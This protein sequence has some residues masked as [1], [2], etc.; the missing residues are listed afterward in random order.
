MVGA[1]RSAPVPCHDEGSAARPW[2]LSEE[3]GLSGG[4]DPLLDSSF[5]GLLVVFLMFLCA[6]LAPGLVRDGGS[7]A[8]HAESQ[9][10]CLLA[11]S[12][13]IA[14]SLFLA[15]WTL[16]PGLFVL[17]LVLEPFFRAH[18]RLLC[19]WGSCPVWAWVALLQ[20][21]WA[22][23]PAGSWACF[24]CSSG[25]IGL[26]CTGKVG[27]RHGASPST[28]Q[29]ESEK[30]TPMEAYCFKCRSKREIAAPQRV[31]LKN[32]NPAVTGKCP[33]CSCK[34]FRMV[35]REVPQ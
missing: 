14:A 29:P 9:G 23:S 32:G 26:W 4:L 20:V 31:T 3:R 18:G 11:F 5:L 8:D 2:V 30:E 25:P 1:S 6:G 12:L 19:N 24:F 22:F 34:M 10:L 21:A 17:A 28:L 15:L 33:E 13:D 35:A 27:F 7:P 16:S